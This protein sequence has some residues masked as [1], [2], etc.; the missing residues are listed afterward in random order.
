VLLAGRLLVQAAL[1]QAG[2]EALTAD[3]FGRTVL[4]AGW[5]QRPYLAWHGAWLPFHTYVHGIAL[6]LLWDLVVVPRAITIL[7]GLASILLMY[8]LTSDLFENRGAGLVGA[9]LLAANPAHLW[10]SSTPLTEMFQTAL[11]LAALA[12]FVPY[13][14]SGRARTAYLSAGLLALGNGFRFESW[15][16]SIVFSLYLIGEAT[17]H[18]RRDAGWARV[19][20]GVVA[21]SLPWLFPLAWIAGSHAATGDPLDFL[22]YVQA[23]K[24]TWY[25]PHR[26]YGYYLE[27]FWRIDPYVT[28]L[29]AFGL[30]FCLWRARASRALTWYV[31]MTVAPFLIFADLHGGQLEPPGNFVRY[32]APFLF[33]VIP[34]LAGLIAL[35]INRVARSRPLGARLVTLIVSAMVVTQVHAAFQF[36]N[37]PAAAGLA[38]GRRIRAL[39]QENAGLAQ[40]PVLIE[41]SYWQY[42]A[43]HAGADDISRLVYDRD[44]D[45]IWRQTISYLSA[46]HVN[47]IRNCIAH[48]DISYI[49]VKSPELRRFVEN[50]LG[51]SPAEVVNSYAFYPVPEEL[52]QPGEASVPCPLQFGAGYEQFRP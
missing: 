7:L 46:D 49:V 12:A 28:V 24:L 2:F 9:A 5:A 45:V 25:G 1:Y 16:V 38:V 50:D 36:V 39:R 6:R 17:S 20:H 4:A 41:V 52:A 33:L 8:R 44:L 51:L 14:K 18:L 42:L 10:L 26:S 3:E 22:R 35:G 40:R 47:A 19:W 21:A 34:A 23:Y 37:D 43:V 11:V 29:G 48:Y 15:M 32:L 13:L 27:T 30:I 31:A